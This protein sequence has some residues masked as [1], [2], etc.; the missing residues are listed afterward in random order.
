[1]KI[2]INITVA[3]ETKRFPQAADRRR[4]RVSCRPKPLVSPGSFFPW[5]KSSL[6]QEY[7]SLGKRSADAT[8]AFADERPNFYV[9]Y[10]NPRGTVSD[11]GDSRVQREPRGQG[12]GDPDKSSP[13][14]R[15]ALTGKFMEL[16][17]FLFCPPCQ[18][19]STGCVT[20]VVSAARAKAKVNFV[21]CGQLMSARSD[22]RGP[23]H[24]PAPRPAPHR[25]LPTPFRWN[26]AERLCAGVRW[27]FS[28]KPA[29]Y[30]PLLEEP[31]NAT[32]SKLQR[33]LSTR[34]VDI[35]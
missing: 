12:L 15:C 35:S 6:N 26:I 16:I 20:S 18:S 17:F 25:R 8:Y 29:G 9:D 7:D 13:P 22:A 28:G 34:S 10:P 5:E 33:T 2:V 19:I 11:T 27:A 14:R 1:M 23:P 24:P 30:E 3:T 32:L 4:R 31:A 21:E